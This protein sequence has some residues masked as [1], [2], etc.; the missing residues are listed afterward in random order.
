M[1]KMPSDR[2]EEIACRM[3]IGLYVIA[4]VLGAPFWIPAGLFFG[5]YTWASLIHTI[6]SVIA[7]GA[8]PRLTEFSLVEASSLALIAF[9]P[10][11]FIHYCMRLNSRGGFF[12]G[13][14]LWVCTIIHLLAM[15]PVLWMT[16]FLDGLG[17]AFAVFL[18]PLWGASLL[19]AVVAWR[20]S[21]MKCLV[22]STISNMAPAAEFPT[23]K[24]K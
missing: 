7:D 1:A 2:T 3:Y 23:A 22:D 11:L 21:S 18:V 6:N 12:P 20:A 14:I 24:P 8:I 13:A 10:L 4:G 19:T 5:S 17:S 16:G 15:I 9:G